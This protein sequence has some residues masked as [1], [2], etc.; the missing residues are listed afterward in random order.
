MIVRSGPGVIF[1][2]TTNIPAQRHYKVIGKNVTWWLVDLGGGHT[3][4]VYGGINTTNF[5]GDPE[6]VAEV[7]APP[8]PTPRPT[9]TC[10]PQFAPTPP[11]AHPLDAARTTLASFFSLLNAGEYEPA[12][13]LY[14]GDYDVL[15]DNNPL[16]GP[17]DHAGLLRNACEMNGYQCLKLLR[18]V[19]QSQSSPTEFQ[20]TVE[21]SNADGTAF[22][23]G[24]CCGA[25]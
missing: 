24:Q 4:W 25:S 3:G 8:A 19:S 17:D 10:A 6:R 13:E 12:A 20:F 22:V 9:A 7:E 16:I 2:V 5:V 11:L 21:F 23:R 15:R 18:I 1:P 14:A